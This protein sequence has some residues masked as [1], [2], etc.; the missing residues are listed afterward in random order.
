[1]RRAT[2]ASELLD[3]AVLEN[4]RMTALKSNVSVFVFDEICGD[5]INSVKRCVKGNNHPF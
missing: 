3:T 5:S 4:E 1:V 2:P